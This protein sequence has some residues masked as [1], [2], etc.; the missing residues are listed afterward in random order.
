MPCGQRA[1]K[2]RSCSDKRLPMPQVKLDVSC[3]IVFVGLQMVD[4]QNVFGQKFLLLK[5]DGI[6]TPAL[7]G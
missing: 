5:K 2:T 4:R 7:L 6:K 3:A 1:F